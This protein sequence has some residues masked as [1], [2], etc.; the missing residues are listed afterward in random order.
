MSETFSGTRI[1]HPSQKLCHHPKL[2][3]RQLPRRLQM[4]GRPPLLPLPPL[5]QQAK[6]TR[7]DQMRFRR[8]RNFETI[9]RRGEPNKLKY[10]SLRKGKRA[11]TRELLIGNF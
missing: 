10:M 5:L 6:P 1:L 3:K 4:P 9:G 8:W 11:K 2:L 7:E